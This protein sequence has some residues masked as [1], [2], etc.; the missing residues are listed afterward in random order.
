[1]PVLLNSL[2]L[3]LVVDGGWKRADVGIRPTATL[4]RGRRPRR[5][6][7]TAREAPA[8]SPATYQGRASGKRR[9]GY[10]GPPRAQGFPKSSAFYQSYY[11][12]VPTFP[13][14][15]PEVRACADRPAAAFFSFGPSTAR[16]LFG[17][18]EKK[19]G[20]GMTQ[21]SSWLLSVRNGR[22]YGSSRHRGIL[23][24]R[25]PP[26]PRDSSA[27]GIVRILIPASSRERLVT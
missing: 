19:M 1:M 4:C 15:R 13:R 12:R 26:R 27:L 5:P 17:K 8:G 22:P 9:A 25:G 16:F 2:A 14:R 18:T 21:P 24:H 6:A 7:F 11:K 20:G 23:I 3:C 10:P